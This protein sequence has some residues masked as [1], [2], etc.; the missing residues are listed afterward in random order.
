MRAETLVI[1][2]E[3]YVEASRAL[4]TRLPVIVFRH[5]VPNLLGKVIVQAS[6]TFALAVGQFVFGITAAVRADI[7]GWENLGIAM[8]ANF[9]DQRV[10]LLFQPP[11]TR[12]LHLSSP[13]RRLFGRLAFQ[14][15]I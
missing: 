4:G 10:P 9:T 8:W 1:K 15:L 13:K 2:T 11:V 14:A 3:E 5:I 6:I 7:P 12:N